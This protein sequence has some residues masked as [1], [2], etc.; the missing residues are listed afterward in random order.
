M[1]YPKAIDELT[2]RKFEKDFK[3]KCYEGFID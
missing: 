1:S 2:L 3:E